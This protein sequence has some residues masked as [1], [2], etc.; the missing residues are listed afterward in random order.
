MRPQG[1]DE[2]VEG[3]GGLLQQLCLLEG[4]ARGGILQE[5][6][7]CVEYRGAVRG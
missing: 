1:F 2:H 3:E 5:P 7:Y 4:R 6:R